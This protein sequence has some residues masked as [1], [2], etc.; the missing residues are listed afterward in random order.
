MRTLF[1]L[2]LV[3]G[4]AGSLGGCGKTTIGNVQEVE[5][6]TYSVAISRTSGIATG[7]EAAIK[8]AVDKGGEFCHA[9]GQKFLLKSALGGTVVFRCVSQAPSPE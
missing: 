9:K 8:A 5:T 7:T 6:G 4:A 3:A 2:A 1:M